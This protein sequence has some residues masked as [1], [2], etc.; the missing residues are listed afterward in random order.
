[1]PKTKTAFPIFEMYSI[2]EL[3]KEPPEPHGLGYSAAYLV[4][5]MDGYLTPSVRLKKTASGILRRT[6]EDL[7]GGGEDETN[8]QELPPPADSGGLDDSP[9]PQ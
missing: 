7:F 9:L 4:A 3:S 6:I 5:I 8:V 2:D 1:M